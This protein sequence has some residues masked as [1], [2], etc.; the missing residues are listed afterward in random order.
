MNS[1]KDENIDIELIAGKDYPRTYREFVKMFPDDASCTDILIK[2]RW[3]DGFICSKC[4]MPSMPWHQTHKRLVCPYCRH[5]TTVTAGTIFD[6]TRTLL[7]TWLEVAWHIT[8]AKNGMS[9]TT[10]ERTLGISYRVAWTILQRF[11]SAAIL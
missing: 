5:Q 8:T 3:S 1:P 4:N 7:T 11:K 10:I 6:R 2:L 9:A